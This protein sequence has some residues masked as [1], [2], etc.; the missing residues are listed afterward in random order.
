MFPVDYE[1]GKRHHGG[2]NELSESRGLAFSLLKQTGLGHICHRH[3]SVAGPSIRLEHRD[4]W[5]MDE[6]AQDDFEQRTFFVE[7]AATVWH[8][9]WLNMFAKTHAQSMI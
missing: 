2:E 6:L 4:F 5:V 9:K 1:R 3:L 7:V 8:D